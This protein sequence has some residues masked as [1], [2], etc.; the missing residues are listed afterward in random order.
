MDKKRILELACERVDCTAG[1]V[2]RWTIDD[3]EIVLIVARG[4]KGNPR[5]RFNVD[6]LAAQPDEP[7]PMPELPEPPEPD[8][9]PAARKLAEGIWR[10]FALQ[11]AFQVTVPF[12][13]VPAQN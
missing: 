8:A 7:K 11:E 12:G 2:L 5:Y 10:L 9:T 13:G 6:E 1:D 3:D 4:I